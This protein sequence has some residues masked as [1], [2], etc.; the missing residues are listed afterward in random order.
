MCWSATADL[1]AG[2][3]IAAIGVV[4]LAQVRRARDL[5]LAALP[6]LLG[7]H[8]LIE[9]AVWHS[10]GG[11]GPA[12]TAWAV[13]AMPLL[14]LWVPC[15]VLLAAPSPAPRRLL[16]PLVAGIAT[17]AVLAVCIA[18]RP[19]TAEVR[20]H[21]VGYV[22]HLPLPGLV[23]AGYLLATVGALLLT[24]DPLLRLLGA[25]VGAGALICF[26]LWKLEYVST[27]CAFA[28]VSAVLMVGWVRRGPRKPARAPGLR[29][30]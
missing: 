3:G 26:L 20:G 24:T 25:L 17:A 18:V 2:S 9:A 21:T 5:P 7:T 1:V 10:G 22:V 15:G 11:A 16:L 28:A 14:A 27:W 8:Q 13:V 4:G 12:T 6:L 29:T 23:I 19:V 30:P